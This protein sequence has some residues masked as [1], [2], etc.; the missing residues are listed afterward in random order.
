MN[1]T[2]SL[3]KILARPD[4]WCANRLAA[5]AIPDIPTIS[6]GFANLDA[7]LPGGGWP[8][9]ALAEILLDG[10]GLGECSLLLPAL[11]AISDQARCTL[12]LAPLHGVHAPAWSAAGI[13]LSRLL[14]AMPEQR[15]DTLW[16]AEHA[17]TSG[18]IGALLCW[19]T[20]I[21][22]A[23]IRRLQVAASGSG[24]LAFLFRPRQAQAQA[25]AASLRLA[26]SAGTR[27][28]LAV[29]LLKRRGPP[30]TR[31]LQLAVPRPLPWREDYE[32]PV[33]RPVP[34]RAAARS[35]RSLAVA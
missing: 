23:Q 9:G 11:R 8:R 13:D 4:V 16:A 22:A 5:A 21:D 10:V 1:A 31:T 2:P 17:L 6:S 33:A 28:T 14:I 12:L 7:E 26:V 34:A 3:S 35:L 18:A 30:C 20:Q 19:T 29:D 27:G 15:R 25:S 32:T 24:A